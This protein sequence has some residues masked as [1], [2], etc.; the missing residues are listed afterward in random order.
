MHPKPVTITPQ[1]IKEIKYIF[2]TKN[3]PSGYGL[4]IGVKAAGCGIADQFVGFDELKEEDITYEQDGVQIMIEKK[5]V[6]FL[7]GQEI[8]FIDAD[9]ERGF[10]FSDK[11]AVR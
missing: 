2:E 6:M 10:V 8:D 4:R 11:D 9:E 7:F 1:A 3:I 5:Q